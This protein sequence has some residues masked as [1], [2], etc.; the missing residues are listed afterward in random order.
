MKV[1]YDATLDD[2]VDSAIRIRERSKAHQSFIRLLFLFGLFFTAIFGFT[3]PIIGGGALWGRLAAGGFCALLF[4]ALYLLSGY[5]L[6]PLEKKMLR[7]FFREQ[8]DT[9]GPI[10]FEVEIRESEILFWQLGVQS[11]IAWK[12]VNAVNEQGNAIELWTPGTLLVIRDRA[13]GSAEARSEF[14]DLCKRCFALS[15]GA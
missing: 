15:R 6:R 12:R 13:F 7:R 5:L 9:E 11:V 2:V 14:L 3:V 8:L 4:T 1:A 10:R